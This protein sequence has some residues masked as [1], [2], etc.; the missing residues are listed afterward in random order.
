MSTDCE[1]TCQ[2]TSDGRQGRTVTTLNAS[3]NANVSPNHTLQ[4]C[5][6]LERKSEGEMD[7]FD[8]LLFCSR[9]EDGVTKLGG[10]ESV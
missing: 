6:H 7:N 2:T 4:L 9:C 10:G 8:H 5:G 3:T 1:P